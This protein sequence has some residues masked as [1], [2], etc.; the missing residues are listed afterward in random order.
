LQY[1]KQLSKKAASGPFALERGQAGS[2]FGGGMFGEGGKETVMLHNTI[3]NNAVDQL[4]ATFGGNPSEGERKIL[5]EMAGSINASD[6]V[7]QEI[8]DRGIKL[9]KEKLAENAR[10]AQQIRGGTY[11]Q[12]GGG[13]TGGSASTPSSGGGVRRYNP[14]TGRIE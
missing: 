12:P 8:Y 3:I 9:A 11:Y 7:R 4:K 5:L 14:D 1:A 2:W 13:V 6:E 10:R